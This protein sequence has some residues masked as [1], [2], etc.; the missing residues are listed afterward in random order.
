MINSRSELF[1]LL[2]NTIGKPLTDEQVDDIMFYVL[3]NQLE[4]ETQINKWIN[5]CNDLLKKVK[6]AS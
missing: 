3:N 4:Y 6:D 5:N 2:K 1:A